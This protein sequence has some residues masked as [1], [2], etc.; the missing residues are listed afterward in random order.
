MELALWWQLQLNEDESW[1]F[2]ETEL[3][4]VRADVFWNKFEEEEIAMFAAKLGLDLV[5]DDLSCGMSID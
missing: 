2:T 1:R 3:R 5:S 4:K